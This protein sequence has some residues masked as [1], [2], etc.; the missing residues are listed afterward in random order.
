ME[1]REP[2]CAGAPVKKMVG[3]TG[4]AQLQG[5]KKAGMRK[6]SQPPDRH[7]PESVFETTVRISML[8]GI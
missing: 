4:G 5:E 3:N 6:Y 7:R 8:E 2:P 1:A